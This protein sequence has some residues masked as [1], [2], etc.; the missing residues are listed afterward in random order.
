MATIDYG[1]GEREIR[2]TYYTMSLYEQE[3]HS[4]PYESV[5][6][7]LIADVLGRQ[8]ISAKDTPVQVNEDGTIDAIVLDYT[9]CNWNVE[10]RAL[11]AMLR[12][13][14]EI[15]KRR[16]EDCEPV[17]SYAEWDRSL[18]EVETNLDEVYHVVDEELQRG[19][20]RSGAAA[21]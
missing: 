20:F 4:C 16:G 14:Y 5:T 18:V 12:T 3:F 15:A 21:S 17:P 6:G 7:D 9:R 13:A 8:V 19:L 11:W 1:T 10:K 2:C